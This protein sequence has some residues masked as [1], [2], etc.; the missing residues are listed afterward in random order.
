MGDWKSSVPKEITMKASF[1]SI[2]H[3]RH[4]SYEEESYI[5]EFLSDL[6]TG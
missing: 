5:G 3:A 4:V 2:T 6:H 1:N